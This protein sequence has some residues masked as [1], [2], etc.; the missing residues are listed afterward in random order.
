MGSL[1]TAAPLPE[2]NPFYTLYRNVDF[3]HKEHNGHRLTAFKIRWAFSGLEPP[4][5]PTRGPQ[6]GRARRTMSASASRRGTSSGAVRRAATRCLNGRG[7][8]RNRSSR[9]PGGRRETSRRNRCWQ[10]I[11]SQG[12][13]A[14]WA[15]VPEFGVASGVCLTA[16]DAHGA[17]HGSALTAYQGRLSRNST[18]G[19]TSG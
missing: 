19:Q 17:G 16:Q 9:T 18:P 10:A 11:P 7:L 12:A 3:R 4:K 6:D 13:I 14:R 8:V 5:L 15:A 1:G 2:K